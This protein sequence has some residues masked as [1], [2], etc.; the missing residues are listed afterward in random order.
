MARVKNGQDEAARQEERGTRGKKKW[1]DWDDNDDT[2]GKGQR[3]GD[4][5]GR[6]GKK[7][8]GKSFEGPS[9]RKE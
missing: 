6:E 4:W 9:W 1:R 8:E 3:P 2:V 5:K 7:R